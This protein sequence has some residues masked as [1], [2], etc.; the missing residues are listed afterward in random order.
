MTAFLPAVRRGLVLWPGLLLLLAGCRGTPTPAL[1]KIG[2]TSPAFADGQTLPKVFT[3]D[4]DNRSPPLSWTEPPPGTRSFALLCEDPD[5]PGGNFSHWVLFNLSPEARELKEGVPQKETL[6][7][8]AAQGFNDADEVGYGSP[9]PPPGK[10]HRYVFRLYALDTVLPL[11]P[12]K[13]TRQQL[14]DAI[15]GHVLAEGQIVGLYG[16]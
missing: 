7:D 5:A 11:T 12:G 6:P 1:P 4:G 10:P 9:G 15:Q 13:A 3:R 16:R 14:L 8:G 2:L